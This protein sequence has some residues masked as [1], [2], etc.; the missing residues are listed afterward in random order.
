MLPNTWNAMVRGI[1][2]AVRVG[3]VGTLIQVAICFGTYTQVTFT[4]DM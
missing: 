2:G 3:L 1:R 4:T